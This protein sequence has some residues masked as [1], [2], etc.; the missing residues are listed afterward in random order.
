MESDRVFIS[1]NMIDHAISLQQVAIHLEE[2]KN[3][4][5]DSPLFKG[6]FLAVPVLMTLAVEI[7]LKALQCQDGKEDI[8]R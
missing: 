4:K 7:A 1:F 3:K 6:V 5:P 2:D 8:D